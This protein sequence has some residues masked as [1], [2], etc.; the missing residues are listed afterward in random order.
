MPLKE[1]VKQREGLWDGRNVRPSGHSLRL[2]AKPPPCIDP[3]AT[4]TQSERE[5]R[6]CSSLLA[7]LQRLSTVS[8]GTLVPWFPLAATALYDSFSRTVLSLRFSHRPR[9]HDVVRASAIS[10]YS[11]V[12]PL[13]GQTVQGLERPPRPT[14][15]LLRRR[16]LRRL[17]DRP[18]N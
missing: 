13:R 10:T 3:A 11:I 16:V 8:F 2:S 5:G 17:A 6:L 1:D 14:S 18:E 9:H 7:T 4:P 15:M 12:Q